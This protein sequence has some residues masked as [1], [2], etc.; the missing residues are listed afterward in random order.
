MQVVGLRNLCAPAYVYLVLSA[1]A[2]AVMLVQSTNYNNLQCIGIPGC[3][4]PS[5]FNGNL[6]AFALQAFYVL[7][8]TWVL[9]IMCSQGFTYTA[10]ALVALPFI[11]FFA[12]SAHAAL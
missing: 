12:G 9:N 3:K 6:G 8:W 5:T 7:F 2:F 11:I 10:W 4:T 1:I